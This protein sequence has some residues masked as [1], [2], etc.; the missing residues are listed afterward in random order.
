MLKGKD[1]LVALQAAEQMTDAELD[2]ART[3]AVSAAPVERAAVD[4][5]GLEAAL[6]KE[7]AKPL[8]AGHT[9]PSYEAGKFGGRGDPLSPDFER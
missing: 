8:V 5:A 6:G 1:I 3:P 7:R 2:A 4:Y 9:E